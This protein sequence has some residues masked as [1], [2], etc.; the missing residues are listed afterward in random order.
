M[1]ADI[2]PTSIFSIATQLPR[3]QHSLSR[4][5]LVSSIESKPTDSFFLSKP[6]ASL[7]YACRHVS[8]DMT[9]RIQP[10][11]SFKPKEGIRSRRHRAPICRGPG[12]MKKTIPPTLITIPPT[13]NIPCSVNRYQNIQKLKLNVKQIAALHGPRV[14]TLAD[15]LTAIGNP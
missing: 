6:T 7:A 3:Q 12:S 8:C 4:N 15:L 1:P 2:R 14:V 11:S 13:A 5:C 9:G 10:L